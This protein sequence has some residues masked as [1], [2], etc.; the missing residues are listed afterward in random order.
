MK[1]LMIIPFCIL[2]GLCLNGCSDNTDLPDD[3]ILPCNIDE[4]VYEVIT[5]MK[6]KLYFFIPD[7]FGMGIILPKGMIYNVSNKIATYACY[8]DEP[9][10][11][12]CNFPDYA[13][14]WK[15]NA[16]AMPTDEDGI[17]IVFSGIVYSKGDDV[18]RKLEL[19]SIKKIEP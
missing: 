3:A 6:T 11:V 17:D 9:D 13:K 12:I 16:D 14:T 10:C 1:N 15:E 7:S 8:Q 4:E 18:S 5:D 2:F 19:T